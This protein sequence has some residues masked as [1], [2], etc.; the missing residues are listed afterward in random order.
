MIGAEINIYIQYSG[1][2]D[3]RDQNFLGL[4]EKIGGGVGI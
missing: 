3:L 2:T 4:L 1:N